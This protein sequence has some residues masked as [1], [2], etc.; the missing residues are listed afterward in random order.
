MKQ[1]ARIFV[2]LLG[3]ALLQSRVLADDRDPVDFSQP[4]SPGLEAGR[5]AVEA[6]DFKS[7]IGHLTK[8]ASETPKDA[9]VH[10]LLGYSYRNLGQFEKALEHYRLAL[11]LDPN[12]RGA[13]EY[14]GELYLEIGQL[15]NAE[16]QLAVL[17]TACPWLG[18]CKEYDDL[19]E[20]IEKYKARQRTSQRPDS[21]NPVTY[22]SFS[23][24]SPFAYLRLGS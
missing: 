20:A 5:K 8:A 9:D 11:N 16:R 21:S 13:H 12:H 17:Y 7:A 6:K 2:T 1:V 14:V 23:V 22:A 24:T 19:K 18:R 15:A 4:R 10:N 3:L